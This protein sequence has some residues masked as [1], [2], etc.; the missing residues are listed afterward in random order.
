MENL[1]QEVLERVVLENSPELIV[2]THKI[3]KG[4]IEKPETVVVEVYESSELYPKPPEGRRFKERN[5]S[6]AT[7]RA[8]VVSFNIY[9]GYALCEDGEWRKPSS[10]ATLTEFELEPLPQLPT[11]I[12][13]EL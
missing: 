3:V 7:I 9:T 5:R 13:Q 4:L 10:K 2:L 12:N 6:W 11:E 1:F 8:N